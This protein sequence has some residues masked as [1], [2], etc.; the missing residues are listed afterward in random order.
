M[1]DS[2]MTISGRVAVYGQCAYCM[3]QGLCE[4]DPDSTAQQYCLPCWAHYEQTYAR[5]AA[6]KR[7]PLSASAQQRQKRAEVR[8]ELRNTRCSAD[9]R[10]PL[11]VHPLMQLRWRLLALLK[12]QPEGIALQKLPALLCPGRIREGISWGD[13]SPRSIPSWC[14]DFAQVIR[15]PL[16]KAA[17]V[18]TPFAPESTLS[19]EAPRARA[20][21]PKQAWVRLAPHMCALHGVVSPPAEMRE[22][23]RV[24][25]ILDVNHVLCERQPLK[26]PPPLPA[27]LARHA[28]STIQPGGLIWERPYA[29]SFVSW[30]LERF[31]VAIWTSGTRRNMR[32][33]VRHLIRRECYAHLVFVWCQEECTLDHAE[34]VPSCDNDSDCEGDNG[35]GEGSCTKDERRM[36]YESGTCEGSCVNDDTGTGCGSS[37][38]HG[39]SMEH[40]SSTGGEAGGGSHDDE[41]GVVPKVKRQ[42]CKPLIKKDLRMVWRKWPYWGPKSTLLVDDDPAKCRMNPPHTALHPSKWKALTPPPG[43]S[44]ELAHNGTLRR[45]LE[46]LRSAPDTQHFLATHQY[47]PSEV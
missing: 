20:L 40:G 22:A 29:T 43:S 25:L 37:M 35:T 33:I 13:A 7:H 14:T 47:G 38:E 27:Q 2:T 18:S 5:R 26:A 8:A 9:D 36:T 16:A 23:N 31:A 1:A 21:T 34:Q 10:Q 42:R 45:Y 3:Q 19:A 15:V 28:H 46:A 11:F 4:V 6:K 32:P 41:V 39:C 12:E 24:L 30:C 44:T 17:N